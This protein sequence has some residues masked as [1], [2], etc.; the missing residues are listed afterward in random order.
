MNL[1]SSPKLN[2]YNPHVWIVLHFDIFYK[3]VL[4]SFNCYNNNQRFKNQMFAPYGCKDF[5]KRYCFKHMISD[6]FPGQTRFCQIFNY[7]F[8]IVFSKYFVTFQ[9]WFA[10]HICWDFKI[11]FTKYLQIPYNLLERGGSCWTRVCLHEG[12]RRR[13]WYTSRYR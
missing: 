3:L 6:R 8:K 4:F 9:D 5:W 2:L 10:I 11:G 13:S 7:L 1:E 12:E